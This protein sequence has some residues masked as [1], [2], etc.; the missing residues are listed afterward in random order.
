MSDEVGKHNKEALLCVSCGKVVTEILDD[1]DRGDLRMGICFDC[2]T[3]GEER[4][5]KRTVRQHIT[6]A[7]INISRDRWWQARIDLA[8]AWERL[9]KTGKVRG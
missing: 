1:W 7:L 6:K 9:T 8:W 4:A 5:L 3:S 2:A